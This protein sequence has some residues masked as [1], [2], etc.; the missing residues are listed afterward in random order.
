MLKTR[1]TLFKVLMIFIG[2]IMIIFSVGDALAVLKKDFGK[3]Y[4][5]G[6]EDYEDGELVTGKVEYVIDVVAQLESSN[7]VYGIPV[8]K[9]VTPYYLCFVEHETE[10]AYGYF[11]LIHATDEDSIKA[12]KD[13]M[14]SPS[15]AKPIAM[16]FK[17]KI[18]PEEVMDYTLEYMVG[19]DFTEQDAR[20]LLAP[21]MLEEADYGQ[22][23]LLPLI[24]LVI[25][26]IPIIMFIVS[27]KKNR[28]YKS[29][30]THY[31]NEAPTDPYNAPPVTANGTP[32]APM[33]RYSADAYEAH[34]TPGG[35][36]QQQ[37]TPYEN[38]NG[39]AS[40]EMDSIDTSHLN[41]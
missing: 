37:N 10:D 1:I 6:R 11:L 5:K 21:Y 41:L 33:R 26:I 20:D 32:A 29:S 16:E 22:M 25:T 8:S 24:G 31:V 7:T 12:M 18:I 35:V 28:A 2:V 13:L 19:D 14:F 30:R 36:P 34:T 39:S 27:A 38:P 15:S 3:L 23:K 4:D 9:S 17:T 40:G